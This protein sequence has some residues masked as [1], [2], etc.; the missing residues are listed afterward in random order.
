MGDESENNT[1]N[2]TNTT[3]FWLM[4][5][6]MARYGVGR[7]VITGIFFARGLPHMKVGTAYHFNQALVEAWE[8]EEEKIPYG[9]R[10]YII[11]PAF[12][13]YKEYLV[14]EIEKAKVNGDTEK[15][16]QLLCEARRM[17][18]FV[19]G[20]SSIPAYIWQIAGMLVVCFVTALIMKAIFYP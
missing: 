9:K 1:Q 16:K 11:L 20:F 3:D 18:I 12:E 5:D 6:M 17:G 14:K 15:Y 4:P 13:K 19:G 2:Q 10:N 7:S 8:I